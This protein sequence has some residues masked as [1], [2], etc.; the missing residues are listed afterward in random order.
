MEG[1]DRNVLKAESKYVFIRFTLIGVVSFGTESNGHGSC[2]NP[3]APGVYARVTSVK[4]WIKRV[5]SDAQDSN[6][7]VYSDY[8][9]Y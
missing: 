2:A 1:V 5:V 7:S 8:F 3:H 4:N 9:E 6:C